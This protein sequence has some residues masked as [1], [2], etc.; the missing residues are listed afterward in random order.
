MRARLDRAPTVLSLLEQIQDQLVAAVPYE[1]I[2]FRQVIE[3]CTEWPRWTRF[4]TSVN[5]QNYTDAG[6]HTFPLGQAECYVSYKDLESDRRDIQI[7]SYPPTNDGLIKLEMKYSEKA[8]A[9]DTVRRILQ[10]FGETLQRLSYN[11]DAPLSL[12]SCP[13]GRTIP[14]DI[15]TVPHE[16][17]SS[18]TELRPTPRLRAF[19]FALFDLSAI[20]DKVWQLFEHLFEVDD[21][22][23]SRKLRDDEPFYHLGGDLIYATQFSGWYWQEGIEFTMEALLENP[24]KNSQKALLLSTILS[25]PTRDWTYR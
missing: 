6:Q 24:T 18:Q 5:H 1:S 15:A 9:R 7:Y 21:V 8:L 3:K 2:G 13:I 11:V 22:R 10:R 23:H 4:S 12:L 17:T 14:L 20:V 25:I 16:L 19:D